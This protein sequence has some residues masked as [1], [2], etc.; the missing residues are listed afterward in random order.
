MVIMA[1]SLGVVCEVARGV[2]ATQGRLGAAPGD[3]AYQ[4]WHQEAGQML[5][6]CLHQGTGVFIADREVGGALDGVEGMQ[7]VGQHPALEQSL[8]EGRRAGCRSG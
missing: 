3:L 1:D 8:G 5:Q 7:V 2:S 4:T 6:Q